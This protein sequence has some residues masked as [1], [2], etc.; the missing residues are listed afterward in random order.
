MPT[1]RTFRALAYALTLSTCRRT[2]SA[3]IAPS[4]ART[5]PRLP[6]CGTLQAGASTDMTIQHALS[7]GREERPDRK[8][9]HKRD[10]RMR[11]R[12][13]LGS[14]RRA[15]PPSSSTWCPS[16]ARSPAAGQAGIASSRPPPPCAWHKMPLPASCCGADASP[17][18][19]RSLVKHTRL[20]YL[21]RGRRQPRARGHMG[22]DGTHCRECWRCAA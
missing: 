12:H 9:S 17:V 20:G 14:F 19:D 8:N 6:P 1:H 2:Y 11:A 21:Q 5:V 10:S 15:L 16:P 13:V 18:S 3:H 22:S 4:D 7:G